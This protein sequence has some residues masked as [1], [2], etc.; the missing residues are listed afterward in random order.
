MSVLTAV[1]A[2]LLYLLYLSPRRDTLSTYGAFVWPVVAALA[3]GLA[4]AWRRGKVGQ[5]LGSEA[6]DH[7]ADQ[8]AAAVHNQW[9]Q[10]AEERELP[11]PIRVTWSRPTKP[12]AGPTTAATEGTKVRPAPGTDR[13]RRS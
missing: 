5:S 3:A 4:W 10:A 2:C 8:L 7:V 12:M 9:K 1:V 6:L 11:G 13:R